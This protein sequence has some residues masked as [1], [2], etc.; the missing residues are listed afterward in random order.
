MI[1]ADVAHLSSVSASQHAVSTRKSILAPSGLVWPSATGV[2]KQEYVEAA[3]ATPQMTRPKRTVATL[4]RM[5]SAV[6]WEGNVVREALVLKG[7]GYM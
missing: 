6:S 7:V 4:V 1:L 2:S 3:D 5:L